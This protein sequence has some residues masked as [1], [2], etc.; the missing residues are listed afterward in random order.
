MLQRSFRW[1]AKRTY[2]ELLRFL[3]DRLALN[4]DYFRVFG[5]APE[6]ALCRFDAPMFDL[7][8]GE[9]WSYPQS[10]IEEERFRSLANLFRFKSRN[11]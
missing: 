9:S 8:L 7:M 10:P 6:A 1:A 4:V 5:F 11:T 2:L 3:P